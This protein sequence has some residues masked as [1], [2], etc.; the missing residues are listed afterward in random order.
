VVAYDVTFEPNREFY[1]RSALWSVVPCGQITRCALDSGD[2]E[3][4]SIARL[5][6]ENQNATLMLVLNWSP[7]LKFGAPDPFS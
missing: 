6:S 2:A 5:R 4:L 3:S 7:L 1:R